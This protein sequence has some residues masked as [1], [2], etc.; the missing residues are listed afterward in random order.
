M[1]AAIPNVVG[2]PFPAAV[3]TILSSSGFSVGAITLQSSATIGVGIVISQN[4]IGTVTPG[5]LTDEDGG[6]ILTESGQPLDLEGQPPPASIAG[7]LTDELGNVITTETG[8]PVQM[9]SGTPPPAAFGHITDELGNII[10]TESGQPLD[11][12]SGTSTP[13]ALVVSL[14]S[15]P[16]IHKVTRRLMSYLHRVFDKNPHPFLAFRIDCDGT[17]LAWSI[18]D[19]IMTLTPT[20]GTGASYYFSIANFSVA[21]LAEFIAALP[22]YSTP[23]QTFT[24]YA[25]LSALVLMDSSND[26]D[27][28]NGDHVYGYT[29][30]LWAYVETNSSELGTAKA[31]IANALL[32]M[33]TITALD[34][35]LDYQG[36]YYNVARNPGELDPAYSPRIIAEVLQPRGNNVAIANAITTIATGAQKVRVID[37]I[38][39]VEIVITYDG[40]ITF[41]GSNFYDAGVGPGSLYGF[42]DVD[43][44]YDFSG[45]ITQSVYFSQIVATVEVFRDAGTQLKTIIFRNDGSDMTIV[46]DSFVGNIRVIVYN[47]YTGDTFR[48]FEDD[49]T[50]RLTEDGTARILES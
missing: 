34:Q 29:N 11:L 8:A 21:F 2:D 12:E 45:P 13:I 48:L 50:V 6:L 44:S 39:D 20:G 19:G 1:S 17:N 36:S 15:I 9:E 33:N 42:F 35:W 31:Q 27:L 37:S 43:F 26:T 23:Y 14:G 3:E 24:G 10:T 32:Q 28:S 41:D 40:E 7:D 4:P 49:I 5:R 46:S 22:G 16:V 38:D 30:L 25:G 18:C 47:D